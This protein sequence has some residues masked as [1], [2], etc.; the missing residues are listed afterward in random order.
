MTLLAERENEAPDILKVKQGPSGEVVV[1]CPQCKAL[2]TV[3]I[4]G[5][6]LTPTRK[7]TQEGSGIYHD[8]G[9]IQPCRLYHNM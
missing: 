5:R 3:Q 4:S 8:C 7:F 2:Q 1:F 9:S 6:K